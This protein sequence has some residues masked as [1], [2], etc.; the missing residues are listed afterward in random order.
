[1]VKVALSSYFV[2]VEK[3]KKGLDFIRHLELQNPLEILKVGGIGMKSSITDNLVGS[4]HWENSI[5]GFFPKN[6]FNMRTI[7]GEGGVGD[8]IIELLGKWNER[9]TRF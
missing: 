6:F 8:D 5:V 1:M 7:R 2:M 3:S 4:F 9:Q